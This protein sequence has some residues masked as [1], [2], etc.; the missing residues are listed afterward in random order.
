M[1]RT[2]TDTSTH[3]LM[4]GKT[5]LLRGDSASITI[6]YRNLTGQNPTSP[7]YMDMMNER[8]EITIVPAQL[9]IKEL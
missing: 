5:E 8:L 2:K 6:I 4:Q 7:G 3:A 9:S 1:P